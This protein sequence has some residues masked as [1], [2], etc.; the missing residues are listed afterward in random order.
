MSSETEQ[1]TARLEKKV[2]SALKTYCKSKGLVINR[3]IQES[4]I[5]KLQELADIEEIP[6]LLKE[7]TRPFSEVLAELNLDG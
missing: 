3:F 4:I 2:A 5:E 6:K 7:P 1:I